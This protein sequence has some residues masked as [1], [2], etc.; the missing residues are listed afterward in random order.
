[1]GL[2]GEVLAGL[3]FDALPVG[4]ELCGVFIVILLA[5]LCLLFASFCHFHICIFFLTLALTLYDFDLSASFWTGRWWRV[6]WK[7]PEFATLDGVKF[8]A[9]SRGILWIDGRCTLILWWDIK[10]NAFRIG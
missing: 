5:R 10:F 4:F 9:L 7:I 3:V 8:D 6:I 2:R 1:M